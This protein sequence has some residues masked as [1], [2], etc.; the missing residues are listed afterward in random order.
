MVTLPI[1]TVI[2][3]KQFELVARTG[4]FRIDP[5][6][7]GGERALLGAQWRACGRALLWLHVMQAGNTA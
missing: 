3:R 1:D 7:S 4:A 2:S 5:S 6:I